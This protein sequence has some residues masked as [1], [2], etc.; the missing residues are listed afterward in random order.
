MF[1]NAAEK[2]RCQAAGSPDGGRVLSGPRGPAR[3]AGRREAGGVLPGSRSRARHRRTQVP[4]Y[5]RLPASRRT[6]H[7]AMAGERSPEV[8]L[9]SR[10]DAH[11]PRPP[12]PPPRPAVPEPGAQGPPLDRSL[13]RSPLQPL[14]SFPSERKRRRIGARLPQPWGVPGTKESEKEEAAS[15]APSGV[16][17]VALGP[18]RRAGGRAPRLL[19]GRAQPPPARQAARLG[20]PRRCGLGRPAKRG[21]RGRGGAE[22]QRGRVWRRDGHAP[23]PAPPLPA[24]AA[25]RATRSLR[26]QRPGTALASGPQRA[27][28]AAT[29]SPATP[30]AP[31]L[32]KPAQLHLRT[33]HPTESWTVS[34]LQLGCKARPLD[35]P[36][37]RSLALRFHLSTRSSHLDIAPS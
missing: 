4:A 14:R 3:K 34:C 37:Q 15:T 5:P 17:G 32:E 8:K 30:R 19:W 11:F 27:P 24:E 9:C 29:P 7:R 13:A 23:V 36:S 2:P 28:L 20:G 33:P 25:D 16:P 10:S 6:E 26:W 31:R 35:S 21:R 18:A 22:A 12:P 1:S